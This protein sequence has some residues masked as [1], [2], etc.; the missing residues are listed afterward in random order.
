VRGGRKWRNEELHNV[1]ASQYVIGVIKS[2]RI[3]WMGHVT[4]MGEM[5]NIYRIF[6]GKTEVRK[7]H[8]RPMRRLENNIKMVLRKYGG[9]LWIGFIWLVKA[10]SGG[11]LGTR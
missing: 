4:R 1:Y 9:T 2:S 8:G 10:T 5:R 11:L 7:P 3:R 6:V